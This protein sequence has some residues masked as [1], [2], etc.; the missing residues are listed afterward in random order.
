MKEAIFLK[1]QTEWRKD[2]SALK[3]CEKS[4]RIGISWTEAGDSVL[5]SAA[6]SGG[7]TLYIG[8]NKDMTLE[9]MDDCRFFA[10]LFNVAA[11][12]ME[13]DIFGD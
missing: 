12:D 2:N 5:Y 4:R 1:Y 3:V 9:F 10:N 6:S 11:Q 13:E 8:Y 7:D